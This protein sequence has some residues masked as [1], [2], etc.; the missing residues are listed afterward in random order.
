MRKMWMIV[1]VFAFVLLAAGCGQKSADGGDSPDAAA[2]QILEPVTLKVWTGLSEGLWNERIL[3]PVQK[4]F[5]NVTLE[6]IPL[7]GNTL[8]KLLSAGNVPDILNPNKDQFYFQMLPAKMVFNL[9]DFIKKNKYDTGRFAPEYMKSIQSFSDKGEIYGLPSTMST[10]S[11]LYNKAIFDKFAAPYPTDKMTWD[12]AIE[13]AKRVSRT[14]GNVQYHGLVVQYIQQLSS[15]LNLE[16]ITRDGKSNLSQWTKP[17]ALW[18]AIY[19]IPGN[20]YFDVSTLAK[21]YKPF[22]EGSIAMLTINPELMFNETK[23]HPD[24]PWDLVTVPTFAEAPNVAPFMN[25]SFLSISP[26]TPYKEQAFKVI[27]YLVSDEVQMALSRKGYLSP[28]SSPEIKQQLGA[29]RPDLAGKN[30]KSIFLH[31][32]SDPYKSPYND[33]SVDALL[34]APFDNIAQGKGDINTNLREGD[35][36]INKKIEE[37]KR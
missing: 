11:L 35:E 33:S 14:D 23:N 25:Y 22:Y 30:L 8:D 27:T 24:L 32:P 12:Q 19:D 10:I 4:K 18:K 29:D 26:N 13:L 36:A 31:T 1:F 21:A 15:Q 9:T 34:R 20:A 37:L 5:P 3:E 16:V 7:Q 28:L 2:E 17:A 6:R